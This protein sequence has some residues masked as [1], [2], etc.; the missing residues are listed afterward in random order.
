M[1]TAL[2]VTGVAACV[3]VLSLTGIIYAWSHGYFDRGHFE[4]MQ[5]QWSSTHQVA[6]LVE[7]WDNQ[8]LG[9]LDD[10]VL[11]GNHVFS[12]VELRHAYHSNAVVFAA[13]SNCL[14]LQWDGPNRLIISCKGSIVDGGHIN[15]QKQRAGGIAISYQNIATKQ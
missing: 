14:A 12:P 15:A 8:S 9:G 5:S 3:I 6:M 7:R 4:I 10:F 1:T 2:R 11:I 13:E